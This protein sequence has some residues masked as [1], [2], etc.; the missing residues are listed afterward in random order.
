MNLAVIGGGSWGTA[1]AVVLAP[2]FKEVRLWMHESDLAKQIAASRQNHVFL[3]GVRVP[4]SVCVASV[5]ADS[6]RGAD[7][8]LGVMPSHFA[9]EVYEALMP[10]LC[11]KMIFVSA[12]KGIERGSLLRMSQVVEQVLQSAFE[13]QVAG[14]SR[15][16]FAEEVAHGEPAAVV[17]ASAQADVAT[18]VQALFAGP[19]FRLYTSSTPLGSKL[20]LL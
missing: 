4:D 19:T 15:L 14:L 13:P 7:I 17:I 16:T 20:R 3:P 1:L 18:R 5:L 9:R 2:K 8:V 12:T 11:K 10:S 6:V